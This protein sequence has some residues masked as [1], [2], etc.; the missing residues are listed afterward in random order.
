MPNISNLLQYNVQNIQYSIRT[1]DASVSTPVNMPT[2]TLEA[3]HSRM[4]L[5]CTQPQIRENHDR[6]FSSIGMKTTSQFFDEAAERGRQALLQK[7]GE[8]ARN[9]EYLGRISEG[10]KITDL[11]RQKFSQQRANAGGTLEVSQTEKVDI[12]YEMGECDISFVPTSQ[13]FS[14]DVERARG[15]YSAPDCGLDIQSPPDI[16]FRYTGG[17]QLVPE[18]AKS[19]PLNMLV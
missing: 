11:Y 1:Q 2:H 6:F 8:Y 9:R 18:S 13:R 14:W 15:E 17:W 5:H 12:S 4:E 10:V 3:D 16:T 19:S 7:I